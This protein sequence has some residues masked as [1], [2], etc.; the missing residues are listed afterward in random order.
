MDDR[1]F[2]TPKLLHGNQITNL[3]HGIMYKIPL[4][5]KVLDFKPLTPWFQFHTSHIG[6]L[7]YENHKK[8]KESIGLYQVFSSIKKVQRYKIFFI[9]CN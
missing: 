8:K 2:A 5:M 9:L 6:I 4:L 7:F 1:F 3:E